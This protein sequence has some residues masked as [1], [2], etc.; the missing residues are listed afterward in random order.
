[1]LEQFLI[2]LVFE[3]MLEKHTL[4]RE[5]LDSNCF[6]SWASSIVFLCYGH[7]PNEVGRFVVDRAALKHLPTV[8][9]H[10]EAGEIWPGP[11][12][13]ISFSSSPSSTPPTPATKLLDRMLVI[14]CHMFPKS[15]SQCLS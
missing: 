13:Q 5:I 1:M 12:H 9:G 8:F 7:E 3:P 10:W 2:L 4:P 6:L 15:S 14:K 11:M